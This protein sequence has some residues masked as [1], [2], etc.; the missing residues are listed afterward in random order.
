MTQIVLPLNLNLIM[1]QFGSISIFQNH[2]GMSLNPQNLKGSFSLEK[3]K[4]NI[5]SQELDKIT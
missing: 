5:L 4:I 1:V 2:F 3:L